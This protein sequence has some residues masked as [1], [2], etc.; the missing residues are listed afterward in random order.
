MNKINNNNNN[1]KGIGYDVMSAI[2]AESAAPVSWWYAQDISN[3]YQTNEN[4]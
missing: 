3:K 4:K 2:M 1:N